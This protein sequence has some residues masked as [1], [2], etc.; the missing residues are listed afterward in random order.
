M[1]HQPMYIIDADMASFQH[2]H[3]HHRHQRSSRSHNFKFGNNDFGVMSIWD[4]ERGIVALRKYYALRDE[5]QTMVS[6]NWRV[7]FYIPFSFFAIE[8]GC[9]FVCSSRIFMLTNFLVAFQA[10][11]EPSGMQTLLDHSL[12]TCGPLPSDLRPCHRVRSRT[13]SRAS[14]YPQT[15]VSNGNFNSNPSSNFGDFNNYNSNSNFNTFNTSLSQCQHAA[16]NKMS[17]TLPSVFHS[18]PYANT[19][20]NTSNT[21][22]SALSMPVLREVSV[23]PNLA[24]GNAPSIEAFKPFSLL[25][26][27]GVVV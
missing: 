14:P 24:R 11:E 12:Q 19:N 2:H 8:C 20:M 1:I 15:R 17:R 27:A 22:R 18:D 6:E 23:N 3:Y 26:L 9:L 10:P 4:D 16:S 13:S 25:I 5:E 21:L 7:W